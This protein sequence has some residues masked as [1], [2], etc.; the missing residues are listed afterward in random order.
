M[1]GPRARLGEKGLGGSSP[2][3]T[4]MRVKT[5]TAATAPNT[6]AAPL[7]A[8]A[9]LRIVRFRGRLVCFGAWPQWP[10]SHDVRVDK[11][12][13]RCSADHR[14]A[15][16]CSSVT[17]PSQRT[18]GRSSSSRLGVDAVTESDTDGADVQQRCPPGKC[19]SELR[20]LVE[21]ILFGCGSRSRRVGLTRGRESGCVA[22][23]DVLDRSGEGKGRTIVIVQ[24]YPAA[25]ADTDVETVVGGK[26]QRSADRDPTWATV[27]PF[28]LRLMLS[29]PPGWITSDSV[30]TSITADPAETGWV[31]RILVR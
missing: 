5:T 16:N 22:D 18:A 23:V 26:D 21:P 29:E 10:W 8:S 6:R 2:T 30:S 24:R 27:V 3:W 17:R 19:R 25:E 14:F 1:G 15:S 20:G 28:T 4:S 31:D 9:P 11:D 13:V 7:S 12:T